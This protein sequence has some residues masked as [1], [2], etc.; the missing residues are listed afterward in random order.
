[1]CYFTPHSGLVCAYMY[2]AA[3]FGQLAVMLLRGARAGARG[4][5]QLGFSLSRRHVHTV[6]GKTLLADGR[7]VAWREYGDPD[8]VSASHTHVG[9]RGGF[10]RVPVAAQPQASCLLLTCFFAAH[11][12]VPVFFMHGNLNSRLFMPSWEKTHEQTVA[13]GARVIA[14]D[15][16][17]YGG[18][19][20]LPDR[21]YE[22]WASDLSQ[23]AQS[24]ALERYC[25]LGYSSGGPNALACALLLPHAVQ[26]CGLCSTDGPYAELDDATNDLMYGGERFTM[27]S[28]LL[29]ATAS[30]E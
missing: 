4:P 1:M 10:L 8:G 28:A 30:A 26:A 16:P 25:V 22:S 15:R 9:Q 23:V 17:G 14:L 27:E 7:H 5:A 18:S 19:D 6:E 13:A 2:K 12:Q 21:T 20:F 11:L 29:R 3:W 24:L